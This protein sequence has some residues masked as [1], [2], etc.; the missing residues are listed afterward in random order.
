MSSLTRA[1]LDRQARREAIISAAERIFIEKGYDNTSVA[2]IAKEAVFTKTTVYKYFPTKDHLYFAVALK[3]Y[4]MLY[5]Y[6]KEG[7][8]GTNGIE[9]LYNT[10]LSYHKFYMEHSKL[11]RITH[12]IGIIKQRNSEFSTNDKWIQVNA[13]ITNIIKNT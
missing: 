4:Q 9:K 5:D 7:C 1:E 13:N 8:I 11:L 12:D 2:E 3:G 6:L 10:G